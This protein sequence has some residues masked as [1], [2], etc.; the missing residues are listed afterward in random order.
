MDVSCP[1]GCPPECLCYTQEEVS[2]CMYEVQFEADG[3]LS[4]DYGSVVE[5]TYLGPSRASRYLVCNE[6]RTQR[7]VCVLPDG[8]IEYVDFKLE[9]DP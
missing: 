7:F 1:N 5:D 4:V 6:C 9:A 2:F 8:T 3:T